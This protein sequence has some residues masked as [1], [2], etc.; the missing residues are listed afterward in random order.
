MAVGVGQFIEYA[1]NLDLVH[2]V[3]ILDGPGF[4]G[5]DFATAAD[6]RTLMGA[7]YTFITERYHRSELPPDSWAPFVVRDPADTLHGVYFRC[8][9]EIQL[10]GARRVHGLIERALL[11]TAR[12]PDDPPLVA[13]VVRSGQRQERIYLTYSQRRLA[14]YGLKPDSLGPILGGAQYYH[15]RG[16]ARYCGKNVAI[17]PSGEFTSEQRVGRCS[18]RGRAGRNHGLSSRPYRYRALG[19]ENPPGYLAF[20]SEKDSSGKWKRSRAITLSVQ[21]GAGQNIQTFAKAVDATLADVLSRLPQD[22]I[23]EHTSDQPQQVGENIDLFMKSLYEAIAA[24]GAGFLYRFLGVARGAADGAGDSH[25]AA[26]DVRH[27]ERAGHRSA[28]GFDRDADYRAR[29]AGRRSGGRGRRDPPRSRARAIRAIVACWLAPTRLANAIMFATIT[30]IVA[31]LP[32]L[33]LSGNTGQFLYSL[34]VVM[35]CSLVASRLVSMT[36]IPLL[37]YYLLRPKAEESAREKRSHGFAALYYRVGRFAIRHR[38]LAL[39]S[40]LLIL[41][42]GRLDRRESRAAVLSK[43]SLLS[44]LHQCHLT[45]GCRVRAHRRHHRESRASRRARGRG[46]AHSPSIR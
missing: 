35:T 18:G 5:I 27:D 8:R 45:G 37:A 4:A 11:A 19:Y 43:R 17:N 2:D 41:G 6:D 33:L 1:E 16:T 38:K 29:A 13:K 39:L 32:F 26:D 44:F 46:T 40:S 25:H 10:P 7:L 30:N 20:H 31:Y 3:R 12:T 36:F 23:V 14:A 42:G 9:R 34:P 28:A 21:M 22:L 24:G 15:R